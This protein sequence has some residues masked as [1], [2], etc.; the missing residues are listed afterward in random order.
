MAYYANGGG[1]PDD[2]VTLAWQFYDEFMAAHVSPQHEEDDTGRLQGMRG[3]PDP[4]SART[5][6]GYQG[7]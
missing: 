7:G 1:T 2:V 6:Q 4:A 3:D 5:D